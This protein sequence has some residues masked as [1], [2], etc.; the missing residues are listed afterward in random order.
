MEES[1]AIGRL[2]GERETLEEISEVIKDGITGDSLKAYL[3][4]RLKNLINRKLTD[5]FKQNDEK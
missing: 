5:P 3:K 4:A 1:F 2:E